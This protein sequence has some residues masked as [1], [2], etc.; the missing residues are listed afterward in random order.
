M[1]SSI[2]QTSLVDEIPQLE[3]NIPAEQFATTPTWLVI[4]CIAGALLLLC[5]MGMWWYWR[6]KH[7]PQPLPPSPLAICTTK[8][9]E[10]EAKLPPMRECSICLSLIIREFLAGQAQDTSLFETHE[11]FSQRIDSLTTLPTSCRLETQELLNS[12]AEL[13]YTGHTE[14]N[15]S[16]AQ[17]YIEQTRRLFQRIIDEQQKEAQH[18]KQFAAKAP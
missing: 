14:N 18:K 7:K 12:L 10:L 5:G 4:L 13:K 16:L 11:E 1:V 2:P 15:A 9:D 8:L 6:R 3:K 17:A